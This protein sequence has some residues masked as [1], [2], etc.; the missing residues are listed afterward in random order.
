MNHALHA[1]DTCA[2]RP[3]SPSVAPF[4]SWPSPCGAGWI[5]LR[6]VVVIA[7]LAVAACG[8]SS[9]GKGAVAA[10]APTPAPV[11][12]SASV[13]RGSVIVQ[14]L[15]PLREPARGVHI[16]AYALEA[17]R[18]YQA[19]TDASGS[20]RFDMPAGRV[21]I[22]AVA[23]D[24]AG[25]EPDVVLKAGQTLRLTISTRPATSLPAGG[26]AG[27]ALAG[28]GVSPDG[29]S[30]EFAVQ[31]IDV[32]GENSRTTVRD[33]RIEPC[34]PD[35]GNDARVV[36][37]DCI[38]GPEGFD[39]PYSGVE[40]GQAVDW[41]WSSNA[42]LYFGSFEAAVLVDQSDAYAAFDRDDR[43][44]FAAKYFLGFATDRGAGLQRGILGAFAADDATSGQPSAL[45]RSPLTPF[46][47]ENPRLTTDARQH[48][49]DADTLATLEG[50][51]GALLPAVD[52]ALD[53]MI[54]NAQQGYGAIL[55]LTSGEDRACGSSDNCRRLRDQV[56]AKSRAHQVRIVAIGINGASPNPDFETLNL[57]AGA[58]YSGAALWVE[59]PDQLA[60]A[61]ADLYSHLGDYKPVVRATFR[62]ESPVDGAF[63]SGRTVLGRVR[64]QSCPWD[65][66]NVTVPFAFT[67]P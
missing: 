52:Q 36:L 15:D 65:C 16:T 48:F 58:T 35:R 67:I 20:A 29:R 21:G 46:P 17:G 25:S 63:A 23:P 33:F 9:D 8:Q 7:S 61:V 51:A 44:V 1:E 40:S 47:V 31:I 38:A 18:T 14:V 64:Y 24:H 56:I 11:T 49:R 60:A 34:V 50:G 41:R 19:A 12:E 45:P 4:R 27:V 28:A 3:S 5:N 26:V 32:S 2:K 10:P 55:V 37:S 6:L 42:S 39:A 43:R 53:F 66:T 62:I 22:F 54:A 13:G 57:L 30:L 59:H